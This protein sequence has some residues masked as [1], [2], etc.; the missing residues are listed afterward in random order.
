MGRVEATAV[1]G[2]WPWSSRQGRGR[3]CSFHV[4]MQSVT[5]GGR[6][7]AAAAAGIFSFPGFAWERWSWLGFGGRAW[8]TARSGGGEGE[9]G[10]WEGKSGTWE[11]GEKWECSLER[12]I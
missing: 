5:S 2:L 1:V 10:G 12:K 8:L 11:I 6:G 9:G 7:M 3:P 4:W